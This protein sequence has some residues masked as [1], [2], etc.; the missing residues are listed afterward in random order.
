MT[1]TEIA[2]KIKELKS[3]LI[4]SHNR[5]DGDTIG[6]ATAL[7]NALLELGIN[8]DIVCDSV[9]PEKFNFIDGV[10]TYLRVEDVKKE[11]DGLIAVDCS[12]PS[13]FAGAYDM[14]KKHKWQK[15]RN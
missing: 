9:I 11:Y 5:P 7:R 12:A 1:I 6:S 3:A 15:L 4:F 8:A 14:F 10:D 2:K 13:M